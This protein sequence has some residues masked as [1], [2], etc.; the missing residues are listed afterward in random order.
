MKKLSIAIAIVL[1]LFLVSAASAECPIGEL[2]CEGWTPANQAQKV[3]VARLQTRISEGSYM[4]ISGC[5]DACV[6]DYDKAGGNLLSR[7]AKFNNLPVNLVVQAYIVTWDKRA[8]AADKLLGPGKWDIQDTGAWLNDFAD[9]LR[10]NHPYF[11]KGERQYCIVAD[12]GGYCP[13]LW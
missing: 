9:E 1:F 12:L 5:G 2:Y 4:N 10:V 7:F 3:N 13:G 6:G 8:Q 11:I